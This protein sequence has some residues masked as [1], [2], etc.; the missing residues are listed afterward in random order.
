MRARAATEPAM[1]RARA[2]TADDGGVRQ[3]GQAAQQRAQC[4]QR[5][6]DDAGALFDQ[7]PD[8]DLGN[9]PEVLERVVVEHQVSKMHA[10][11]G[12]GAVSLFRA[13]AKRGIMRVWTGGGLVRRLA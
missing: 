7:R 8:S 5:P 1:K 2:I 9:A 12:A 10:C 6:G 4:G 13:G 11:G 3:E